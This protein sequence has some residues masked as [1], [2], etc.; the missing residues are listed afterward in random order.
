VQQVTDRLTVLRDGQAQG[1]Y[2]SDELSEQ[3]IIDLI[4]GRA[5]DTAFPHKDTVRTSAD[6]RLQLRHFSGP[7]FAS[8]D[9]DVRPGE[10]VGL[11]GIDGNGQREIV[12]ALAG[13]VPSRGEVRVHGK[14]VQ[15]R[16]TATAAK[17]GITY[18]PGDRHREGIFADLTVRENLAY[19]NLS[20]IS[21]GGL[22]NKAAERRLAQQAVKD[23]RIKTPSTESII[24]ALS[25]GNQQKT[26]LAGVLAAAPSI[27]LADEPTQGVDIGARLEI[28]DELR[29]RAAEGAAV[30]VLSSDAFEIAGL[31]DRV[32]VLSRGKVAA[33]LSGDDVN[34][35]NIT[36]A[37]L[38][39][40]TT[41]DDTTRARGGI[42]KLLDA[43]SAPSVLLAIAVVAL[44]SYTATRSPSYLSTLNI[45]NL[46]SLTATLALV[47]IGQQIIMVTGGIDLSVGPLMGLVVVI[48]SFYLADG[49]APVLEAWGWVL[50]VGVPLVVGA[51]NWILI[52]WVRLHPMVATLA[53]Y[54]GIQ[55]GSLLLRPTP[56]GLISASVT[57]SITR[58]AGPVPF[59]VIGVVVMAVLLEWVLFRS[60][61]GVRLRGVGSREEAARVAGVRPR[62]VR[63]LAH[64]GCSLFAGLAG[65]T[66]MAQVGSGDASSGSNYTLQS[67]A[68]IVVAGA[69]VFGGRGSF[70]GAFMGALLLTQ[71]TGATTFLEL[72][73]AWQSYLLGGLTVLAVAVYSVSRRRALAR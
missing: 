58:S 51:V 4:V 12:R 70:I 59:V 1:T 11:A 57:D 72:N 71:V 14:K 25:G 47:A 3:Q 42:W 10:I 23:L 26:V 65:I 50:I 18:L 36:G 55:A 45:T 29:R 66:L 40:T 15:V 68:A 32:L 31:C 41:R 24:G 33:T 13:L 69:S 73:D 28:Y 5:V 67:I 62:T 20:R 60:S 35:R 38:T 61:L 2:A 6:A 37:V 52:E 54:T 49:V 53:T 9:L 7:G 46:L 39:S 30:L 8:L 22:I 34:E 56:D 16:T 48:G 17:A 44:G 64:L 21:R 63:L 27:I 43:T 19:R